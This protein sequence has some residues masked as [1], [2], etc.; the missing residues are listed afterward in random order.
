[1]GAHPIQKSFQTSELELCYF[2]WG[3]P[4]GPVIF[5]VHATGFHARCWDKVVAE[6]PQDHRIIAVDMRGHGRSENKGSMLD[7]SVVAKDTRE[8]VKHLGFTGAIGV[9]H[10]MGGHCLT[11]VAAAQPGVFQ[12]LILIDPVIVPPDLMTN[13]RHSHFTSP[14]E[15]PIARRRNEWDS[16]QAMA[17]RFADRHPYSLWR[18][19]VLDD[20]CEHG[21]IENTETGKWEL[22]CPPVIEASIYMG[23]GA[24]D[25]YD[26]VKAVDI[27]VTVL[28]ADQRDFDNSGVIDFSKS[29]TW[30]DLADHFP[31]GRDVYL[32]HLSHFMPMEDPPLIARYIMGREV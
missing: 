5:L 31:Q 24:T 3:N 12:K 13:G 2:E 20:Y 27:P 30:P 6:L 22:A 28:R 23:S 9:G 32:P 10:S 19:D 7:W 1:M 17:T 15:H 29:P 21:L 16:A 11:Q 14:E 25:I 18:R 26:K 8:L 4:E